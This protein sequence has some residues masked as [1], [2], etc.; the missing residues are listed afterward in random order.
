MLHVKLSLARR[1]VPTSIVVGL[2]LLC[3]FDTKFTQTFTFCVVNVTGNLR[4]VAQNG[5]RNMKFCQ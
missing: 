4:K 3:D 5:V 2:Y 1:N